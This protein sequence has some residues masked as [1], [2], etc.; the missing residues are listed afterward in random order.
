MFEFHGWVS[1][2]E[3]TNGSVP[4]NANRSGT[5]EELM[6]RIAEFNDCCLID[7]RWVNA[8][9]Q[10]ALGGLHN[11][12]D[13]A[14]DHLDF[15]RWIATWAPGSYGLLYYWDDEAEHP[16]QRE[17]FRVLVMARGEVTE[18]TDPFLSPCIPVIEDEVSPDDF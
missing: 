3:S 15:F 6:N 18:R 4:P 9:F 16:T 1:V 5:H 12:R 13:S 2:H 8:M 7:A 11:H 17:E 10:V 14:E